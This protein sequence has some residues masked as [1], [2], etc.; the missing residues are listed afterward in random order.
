MKVISPEAQHNQHEL[1]P[2][3]KS[4]SIPSHQFGLQKEEP[5]NIINFNMLIILNITNKEFLF[6]WERSGKNGRKRREAE[7][8]YKKT[9]RL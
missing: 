5:C 1:D 7:R 4:E 9:C 8:K 2:K 3:G 6:I